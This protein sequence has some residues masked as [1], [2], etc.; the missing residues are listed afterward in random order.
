MSNAVTRW[1]AKKL[2]H[3]LV[4][5]VAMRRPPNFIVGDDPL[6]PYLRRWWVIPRNSCFNIYLHQF[7]RD[8]DDR[9][10]HDH[11][12]WSVSLALSGDM[13]EH[14]RKRKDDH[15]RAVT[16]G[17]VIVRGGKFAHRMVVVRPS[18]TLFITGPRYREWG[19]LCPNGWIP[20]QKFVASENPG[21]I[22]RG[23]GE[24]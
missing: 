21:A 3:R 7:L 1:I 20:W 14:Y 18:W 19:F 22:G 5:G 12:F 2:H 16:V 13:I 6:A 8:D 15:I 9:A 10:L 23:C 24:H 17:D 11:P 4:A